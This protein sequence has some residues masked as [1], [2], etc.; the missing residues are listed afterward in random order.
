MG[1]AMWGSSSL[2]RSRRVPD[3][4]FQPVFVCFSDSSEIYIYIY[5]HGYMMLYVC[6][7]IHRNTDTHTQIQKQDADHKP[8]CSHVKMNIFH[9]L[10][11]QCT[12]DSGMWKGVEC[13]VWSV[14]KVE[15]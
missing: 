12:V 15:R 5:T 10:P 13:K 4:S 3:F 7:P 8:E 11:Y 14:K 1:Q 6:T 9:L 2:R